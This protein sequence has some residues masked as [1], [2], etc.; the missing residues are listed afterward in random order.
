MVIRSWVHQA[1]S[2]FHMELKARE[3]YQSDSWFCPTELTNKYDQQLQI[4]HYQSDSWFEATNK[5]DQQL[6]PHTCRQASTKLNKQR[7]HIEHSSGDSFA[8]KHT[9][10]M[11]SHTNWGFTRTGLSDTPSLPNHGPNP[12][13]FN[14]VILASF[15]ACVVLEWGYI[16]ISITC[17]YQPYPLPSLP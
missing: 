9:A 5:Y 1:Q 4:E 2:W 11:M 8:S 3:C 16:S 7:K 6:Q 10:S 14:G 12:L 13:R 15:P 17:W